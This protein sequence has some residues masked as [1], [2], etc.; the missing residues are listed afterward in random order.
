VASAPKDGVAAGAVSDDRLT[1]GKFLDRRV[2]VNH[3][4]E[5]SGTTLGDHTATVRLDLQRAPARS[6][7]ASGSSVELSRDIEV[8]A[9]VGGLW[10]D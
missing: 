2:K 6:P 5:V 7:R 4:G 8:R 1:V 3:P 10:L 9:M